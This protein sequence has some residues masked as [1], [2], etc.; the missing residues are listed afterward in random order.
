MIQQ[1]LIEI[2]DHICKENESFSMVNHTWKLGTFKLLIWSNL[3][4][5]MVC[6]KWM[7]SY[8]FILSHSL[9]WE[10]GWEPFFLRINVSVEG[11]KGCGVLVWSSLCWFFLCLHQFMCPRRGWSQLDPNLAYSHFYPP[12]RRVSDF[13][14]IS[15]HPSKYLKLFLF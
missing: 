1:N 10:S 7:E 2:S 15:S 5:S 6:E 8:H 4:K 14:I 13:S 12:N 11:E 9:V 3:F